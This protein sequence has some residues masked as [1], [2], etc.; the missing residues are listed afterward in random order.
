[1]NQSVLKTVGV[2][3][4]AVIAVVSMPV[5]PAS[6]SIVAF[7]EVYF[8]SLKEDF[9]QRAASTIVK[10]A[11]AAQLAGYFAGIMKKNPSIVSLMKVDAKGIVT[12]ERARNGRQ[13]VKKR[14]VVQRSWFDKTAKGLKEAD[15][16]VIDR[17]GRALIYWSIPL[18]RDG[19]GGAKRFNGALVAAVDL[20][21]CFQA[22]AKAGAQP[23]LIR[24]NDKTFYEGSWKNTMIFVE[25]RL[26]I[27]GVENLVV[28]YQ[29]SDVSTV[30]QPET[31]APGVVSETP[32]ASVAIAPAASPVKAS[33]DSI[34]A[35]PQVAQVSVAKKNMP[36]IVSLIVLIIVVSV[37]LIIQVADRVTRSRGA[38][39]ANK[40]DLL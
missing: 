29:K 10:T 38:R 8:A 2:Y 1:M 24:L 37:L 9:N 31:P 25:N 26:N 33:P 11:R 23:F 14:S 12:Y 18:L 28:R 32:A 21:A 16:L 19:P 5:H 17:S 6:D 20:K 27:P 36:F 13:P 35:A 4:A 15:C 22:I 39:S 3:L 40:N 34:Q 7:M 30:P